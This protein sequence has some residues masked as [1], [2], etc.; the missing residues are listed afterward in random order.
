MERFLNDEAIDKSRA[1]A[2]VYRRVLWGL[3]VA[4]VALFVVLCLLTR[5]GNA[6]TMLFTAMISMVLA[7]WVI[8]ALRMFGE[9]PAR[10]EER[11]LTGLAEAEKQIR[12]GRI[13][14][15]GDT[16]RIPGSVRVRK[17]RLETEEEA[18]SL[19]LNEKLTGKMP[20][21]GTAVRAETARKFITGLERLDPATEA[22]T[23]MK[24][25]RWKTFRRAA[26]R[27]FLPAV[28]WAMMAV[29]LTGFVFNQIT[30]TAPANKIVLYADCE[31]ENAPE[32]AE[33]LEK[34]LGGAVRM[35]KIH[36]FSY[37]MFDSDR[38]KQADLFIVPDSRKGE[39]A[40]WFA[41]GEGV[42]ACDPAAGQAIVPRTFLYDPEESYQLYLG[43]RSVHLE[44]GLARRAADL[45]LAMT[46]PVKE[47]TP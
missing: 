8:L 38:L 17:I 30:D 25:S 16:F 33:R 45:L 26:G 6:R 35:V 32:L 18:L 28:L 22:R 9:E 13:F 37:A 29:L 2:R 47:D 12:E 1:R 20:P 43:G 7:G 31:V 15:T 14:V 21:D 10:A 40:E 4:A 34:E 41:P 27:F 36:P 3:A 11:H 19:N 24:T 44:D 46:E 39:Y 42:T 23:G 5:T